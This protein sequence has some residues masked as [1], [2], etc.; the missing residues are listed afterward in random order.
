MREMEPLQTK[1][2]CSSCGYI[3]C[4]D[5]SAVVLRQ[6]K[7]ASSSHIFKCP[8]GV[9]QR[10]VVRTLR[11]IPI[12]R[13]VIDAVELLY[14]ARTKGLKHKYLLRLRTP[15]V[16]A[17]GLRKVVSPLFVVAARENHPRRFPAVRDPPSLRPVALYV[18]GIQ[19]HEFCHD[20]KV[21]K[22]IVQSDR[23]LS[24]LHP[25]IPQGPEYAGTRESQ[26]CAG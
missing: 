1:Q 24:A 21:R 19:M 25:P 8:D 5:H 2:E 20:S 9:L 22:Q 18:P 11:L 12:H 15:D 7:V 3:R 10:E 6:C 13:L 16:R 26:Y 4:I 17:A 23:E 14:A